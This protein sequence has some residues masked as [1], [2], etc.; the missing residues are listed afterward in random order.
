MTATAARNK[1]RTVAA[2]PSAILRRFRATMAGGRTFSSQSAREW[3]DFGRRNAL[4]L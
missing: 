4:T 3:G 1:T 2:T